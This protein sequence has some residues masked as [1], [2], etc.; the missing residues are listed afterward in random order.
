[1]DIKSDIF[2]D[3]P[4]FSGIRNKI[5]IINK[6]QTILKNILIIFF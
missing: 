3:P 6:K 5:N 4:S 1:V 2:S